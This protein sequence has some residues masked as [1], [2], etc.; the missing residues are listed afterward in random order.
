MKNFST[1][2]L[3]LF[4]IMFWILR[5][6]V[7]LGAEL[8][9]DLNGLEPLNMQMEIGLLFLTLVCII[10]VI[11]RKLVG[12]L[13]YLLSYGMYYGVFVFNNLENLQN[14]VEGGVDINLYM[15]LFVSLVGIIIPVAVMLDL[16]ADKNRKVHPKDKKTDWFYDNEQFDRKMDERADKNNYRTL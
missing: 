6:V 8:K 10:L 5:V 2:L 12:G 3:V 11:K 9:W 15:Q 13:I 14:A 7:A 1:W 4:M 16:F